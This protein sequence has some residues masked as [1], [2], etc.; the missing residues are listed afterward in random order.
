MACSD[1]AVQ[2]SKPARALVGAGG[3]DGTGLGVCVGT[4]V[5]IGVGVAVGVGLELGVGVGVGVG[6]EG[7]IQGDGELLGGETCGAGV[8]SAEFF[9]S[10]AGGDCVVTWCRPTSTWMTRSGSVP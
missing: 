1:G 8:V 9:E 7:G 4:P 10:L 5:P 2:V 3:D 6:Q